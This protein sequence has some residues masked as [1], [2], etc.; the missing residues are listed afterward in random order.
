MKTTSPMTR[1]FDKLQGA[2]LAG[3]VL[4]AALTWTAL[5]ATQSHAQTTQAARSGFELPALM[6]L[7]AQTKQGQAKFVEE[8]HVQGFA[9][10]LTVSG[11]LEF[12]APDFFER[13]ALSPARETMRVQGDQLT[14]MRGNQRRS[15]GLDSAPEAAAMV[16]A[17]RGTLTGD[18]DTLEKHFAVTLQGAVS[19]WHMDLKPRD[20]AIQG[21]VRSISLRGSQGMVSTIE[22]FLAN[23]DRSTMAITPR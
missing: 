14:W 3:L 12:K 10:P 11:E 1:T 7:L 18:R 19:Q 13:R 23:G 16:A 5:T 17:M 4:G 9:A 22:V 20:S 15:M 21:S 8:R 6:A 2:T